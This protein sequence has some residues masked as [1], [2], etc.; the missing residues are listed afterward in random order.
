MFEIFEYLLWTSGIKRSLRSFTIRY[1]QD[2]NIVETVLSQAW[3]SFAPG[4][5]EGSHFGLDH[6]LIS[7]D[8][9]Q[10][11]PLP[12]RSLFQ[13]N[14]RKVTSKDFAFETVVWIFRIL[15]TVFC[16]GTVQKLDLNSGHCVGEKA[17]VHWHPEIRQNMYPPRST[18]GFSCL[19]INLRDKLEFRL[20]LEIWGTR[21]GMD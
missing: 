11:T 3:K 9:N 13:L 17:G 15:H 5:Y 18:T 8:K 16:V 1:I 20:A 19:S 2:A 4:K 6:F 12:W 10:V 14:T 7:W 21:Q